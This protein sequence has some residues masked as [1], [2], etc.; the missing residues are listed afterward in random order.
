MGRRMQKELQART[1]ALLDLMGDP[2]PVVWRAVRR[3]LTSLGRAAGP[4]LRRAA[5]GPDPRT[6]GRARDFLLGQAREQATRRLCG[7][8]RRGEIQLESALLLL[9]RLDDPGADL[10]PYVLALDALAAEVAGRVESRPPGA[11]RGL[12]LAEY[13]GEELGYSGIEDDYHH[14]D[15]IYLHRALTRKRG[16][17]LTLT[18]IYLLVA[19][20]AG[21]DAA[22]VALPGHVVLR[23]SGPGKSLLL[24]PFD[25]GSL[26]SERDC[27]RYLAESRLSF[28]PRWLDDAS[29]A[30]L[31]ERQLRN[32]CV[33]YRR[34]QLGRELA[35]VGRVLTALQA[36]RR[37]RPANAM[38]SA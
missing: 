36:G 28:D 23:L 22:A 25:G 9:S 34:R 11:D 10:R 32:L 19:R 29:D 7:Y 26:L 5:R 37:P 24:D 8:A 14:P 33:S 4:V 6:R 13:L 35:L 18:A 31:F 12:V 2:S 15:N 38:V 21:I 27:L 16:I 3:E 20:R 30:T 1:E 17:P